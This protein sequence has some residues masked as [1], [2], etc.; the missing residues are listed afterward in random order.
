MVIV[1]AAIAGALLLVAAVALSVSAAP[2]RSPTQAPT[3]PSQAHACG[4]LDPVM[5]PR[6]NMQQIVKQSILLEEHI[7]N[8]RKRCTDC[9]TKHFL[10]IIG[11][12]EE[13]VSLDPATPCYKEV[14]GVYSAIFEAWRADNAD[15]AVPQQL[16]AHR[17]RLMVDYFQTG[18]KCTAP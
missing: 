2:A 9:I 6:Y 15:P 1:Y 4:A 16:R 11:L 3:G 7:N 18:G 10:H 5:D 8:E 17:K 12:A 13:A 14:P